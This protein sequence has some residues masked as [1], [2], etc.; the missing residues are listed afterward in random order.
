MTTTMTV[1]LRE[2]IEIEEVGDLRDRIE[3]VSNIVFYDKN[4][5]ADLYAPRPNPPETFPTGFICSVPAAMIRRIE[6]RTS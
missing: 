4:R 6:V 5:R 1:H 3:N 2:K